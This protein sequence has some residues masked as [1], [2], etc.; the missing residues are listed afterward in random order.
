MTTQKL[1]LAGIGFAGLAFAAS[2][3]AYADQAHQNGVFPAGE[4]GDKSAIARIIE[5]EIAE[6]DGTMVYRPARIDVSLGDTVRFVL[7]NKGALDHEFV[8]GTKKDNR[9]HAEMMASMPG[10]VHL[11]KNMSQVASGQAAELTWKF[12]KNGEFEFACLITG[13]Y[14]AGMHGTLVVK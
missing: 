5:I 7:K 2:G 14:E 8:L 13:H 12:T 3:F 4:V 6:G 1:I 11:E 9:E 10:M